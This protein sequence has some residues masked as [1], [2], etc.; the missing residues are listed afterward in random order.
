MTIHAVKKIMSKP[1][2][3]ADSDADPSR[4]GEVATRSYAATAK[5]KKYRW[6]AGVVIVGALMAGT[7]GVLTGG[8]PFTSRTSAPDATFTSLKGEHIR[9][10]DLRGKMV[11]VNFWATSCTTCIHEMP[12]MIETYERFKGR[13][14]DFIAVAMSYDPPNYVLN[15]T[16][17]RKLP[18]TVALDP[19]DTLAKAFGHV[20]L[21]PTTFLIDK[22]GTILK[23]FVGEPDFA[24]LH[25]LLD[26]NLGAV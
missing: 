7:L 2:D 5:P 25:Q 14:L 24:A 3:R 6:I 4:L 1:R 18:F 17:T 16:E 9:L 20:K 10:K 11:M 26:K 22:D 19:Q 13:G 15:Y 21:T 12:Q 8:I 23:R